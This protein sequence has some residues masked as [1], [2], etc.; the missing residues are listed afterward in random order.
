[1]QGNAS[2]A[3]AIWN[4]VIFIFLSRQSYSQA[5]L[6]FAIKNNMAHDR[7]DNDMSVLLPKLENFSN[8]QSFRIWT[9]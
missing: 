5:V 4:K 8:S 6:G 1:M 3:T 2:S 9:S 7:S